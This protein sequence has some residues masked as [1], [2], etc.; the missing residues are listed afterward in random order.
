MDP[1]VDLLPAPGPHPGTAGRPADRTDPRSGPGSGRHPSRRWPRSGRT[2]DPDSFDQRF[3][4]ALDL[5]IVGP[6][7]GEGLVQ[8]ACASSLWS[9]RKNPEP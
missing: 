1:L 7:R 5:A 3:V 6:P 4:F 8:L 2:A 9:E